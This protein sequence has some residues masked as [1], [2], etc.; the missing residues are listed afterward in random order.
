MKIDKKYIVH[1]FGEIDDKYGTEE[2][3]NSRM[4]KAVA[5]NIAEVINDDINSIGLECTCEVIDE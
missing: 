3:I 1:I 5:E 4:N 2:E